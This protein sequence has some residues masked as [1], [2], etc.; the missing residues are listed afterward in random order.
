M[1]KTALLWLLVLAF[2]L[3]PC[4]ARATLH[5]TTASLGAAGAASSPVYVQGWFNF[6]VSGT[7][8]ATVSLQRSFDNG[9]T[10][11]TVQSYTSPTEDVG[12]E[13][14]SGV[15]YRAAIL[16]GDYTSGTAT[17]RISQ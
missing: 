6:S 2:S 13:P 15:C 3:A 11:V 17:V 9:T 16:A 4:A 5:K 7:F 10:W 1:I 8:S 12:Y 14:E